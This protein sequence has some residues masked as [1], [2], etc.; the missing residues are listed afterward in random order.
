[1]KKKYC[2]Y[3]K[4]LAGRCVLFGLCRVCEQHKPTFKHWERHVKIRVSGFSWKT[5]RSGNSMSV[6]RQDNSWWGKKGGCPLSPGHP[7][8]WWIHTE[9]CCLLKTVRSLCLS[10]VDICLHLVTRG[11]RYWQL[12]RGQQCDTAAK[13]FTQSILMEEEGLDQW[14]LTSEESQNPEGL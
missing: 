13:N 11:F 4:L 10:S 7:L 9:A 6:F 12:N 1:M 3:C 14:S 5:D 2:S 8:P